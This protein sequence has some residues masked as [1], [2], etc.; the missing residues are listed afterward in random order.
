[1]IRI[2]KP[3]SYTQSL[4]LFQLLIFHF[5]FLYSQD[6]AMW[7]N[8]LCTLPDG[9]GSEE[10]CSRC[11][12]IPQQRR[13][14]I[15]VRSL[16]C[17]PKRCAP[18]FGHRGMPTTK[19]LWANQSIPRSRSADPHLVFEEVITQHPKSK[20]GYEYRTYPFYTIIEGCRWISPHIISS[21]ISAHLVDSFEVHDA[22]MVRFFVSD[23]FAE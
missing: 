18:H 7:E 19:G 20:N 2:L 15:A 23:R 17:Y 21:I 22:V 1:M 8:H 10:W 13:Q 6:N 4:F 9:A 14:V 5:K 16:R 12:S 11:E 3:A